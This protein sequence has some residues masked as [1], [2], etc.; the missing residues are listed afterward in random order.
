VVAD[1]ALELDRRAI[2]AGRC[3]SVALH[4]QAVYREHAGFVWRVLRGMGVSD[5]LVEDAVQDVFVV[6]HRRLGEFDGRHSVKTWLFAIAY[7]VACDYRRKQ[8]RGREHDALDSQQL[9]D[10][11]PSPAESAE[12]AQALRLLGT[13]LD[14]IADEKRAVLIL[15]EVE[16]M[17]V[18][19]IAA[20]TATPLNTVYSRLRRGRQELTAAL[21]AWQKVTK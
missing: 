9:R 10:G 1:A 19:E 2:H 12:Q 5:A 14:G 8:K 3:V 6:V 7:R 11:A 20:V 13:L 18:P 17:T 16:G 21:A 4:F 15:A